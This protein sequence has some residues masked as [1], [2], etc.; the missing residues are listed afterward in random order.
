MNRRQL[1]QTGALAI[2]SALGAPSARA[3]TW[4]ARPLR[5]VVVYPGG[6]VSDSVTRLPA[7]L[8]QSEFAALVRR[9]YDANERIVKSA[10]IKAD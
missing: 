2:G 6:G 4:P 9:E 7:P 3:Q 5:L 10:N 8:S 1:L